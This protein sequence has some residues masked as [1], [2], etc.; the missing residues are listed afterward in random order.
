LEKLRAGSVKATGRLITGTFRW[1]QR[2]PLEATA[3]LVLG[4]GGAIFPPIWLLGAAL[5]F[6]SRLWDYRDRWLGL[7][8]PVL[9]TIAGPAIAVSVLGGKY[10]LG[11]DVHLGWLYA[12]VSARI[13]A[14][15]GTSYLVWRSVHGR[16][17]PTVPPWNKPRRIA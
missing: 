13:S 7:G 6:G 5:A 4:V 8:G 16:R 15:L 10:T 1:C 2:C 12:D 11:H 9:L 17:P 14:V 3:S